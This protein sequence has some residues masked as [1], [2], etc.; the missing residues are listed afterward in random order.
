ML[1]APAMD[2]RE[3]ELWFASVLRSIMNIE[4]LGRKDAVKYDEAR[5]TSGGVNV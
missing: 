1:F 3:K 2:Q 5:D 4:S